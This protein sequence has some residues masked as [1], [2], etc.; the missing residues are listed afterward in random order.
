MQGSKSK[1][2]PNVE[3]GVEGFRLGFF[4]LI[5]GY[6]GSLRVGALL[7]ILPLRV[8]LLLLLLVLAALTTEL[9]LVGM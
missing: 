2:V 8:A 1:K 4:S 3:L 6:S 5:H 9:M 7:V